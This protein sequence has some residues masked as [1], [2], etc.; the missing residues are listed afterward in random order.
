MWFN[1]APKSDSPLRNSSHL[2]RARDLQGHRHPQYLQLSPRCAALTVAS[3]R[4]G[5]SILIPWY[6]VLYFSSLSLI[7]A[8]CSPGDKTRMLQLRLAKNRNGKWNIMV[9]HLVFALSGFLIFTRANCVRAAI[10]C[11]TPRANVISSH[12]YLG[13]YYNRTQVTPTSLEADN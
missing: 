7:L 8:A 1:S 2:S 6:Q 4:F 9:Y 10:G 11:A 3:I 5:S 13:A 12:G